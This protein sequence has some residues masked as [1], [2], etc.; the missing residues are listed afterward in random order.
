MDIVNVIQSVIPLLKLITLTLFGLILAHPKSQLIP[1]AAFQLLSRL[2]FTLFLPYLIFINLGE[3]ITLHNFIRWWFIPVNVIISTAAGC[4]LGLVVAAICRP[5]PEFFRLTVIMT[6]FGN[7]GNL[8]LAIVAS[9]CHDADTPY[10]PECEN[11]GTAYVCFAQWVAMLLV[12]TLVYHMM[13]PVSDF[14]HQEVL[15]VGDEIEEDLP[16][17]NNLSRPLLVEAEWPG[18]E[19]IATE[20]CKTPLIATVFTEDEE[21]SCSSPK[22][23]TCLAEPKIV[24][25]IKFVANRTPFRHILQPPIFAT[26]LALFVGMVPSLKPFIYGG[27]AP[28]AFITDSLAMMS[29][30]MVPSVMLVLGGMLAEGPNESRL[31][32]RTTVGIVVARLL[33]LPLVGIGVVTLGDG[34]KIFVAG[35]EMYKLVVLLQYTTP[36]A[37]LLGAVGSLRGYAAKEAAALLFWQHIFAVFSLSIYLVIYSKLL[38]AYD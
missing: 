7:T 14:H 11:T 17:T 12:Y 18:V 33:V 2:V 28:L 16:M 20:H 23:I 31:G 19:E 24:T 6:P 1:K 5:P 13:E 25:K 34:L 37:I 4:L 27:D 35:D 26:V 38:F 8:P 22:S 21:A 30:A 29:E 3:T 9:V 10:G 32:S 15:E 36:S